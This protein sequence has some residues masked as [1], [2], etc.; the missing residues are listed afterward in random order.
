[1]RKS[2]IV[3]CSKVALLAAG[4][5]LVIGIGLYFGSSGYEVENRVGD[6]V[7]SAGVTPNNITAGDNITVWAN[8]KYV[9]S[10]NF[11]VIAYPP[12]EFTS[13]GPVGNLISHSYP[14]RLI[15]EVNVWPQRSWGETWQYFK[16]T[17]PGIYELVASATAPN[18]DNSIVSITV[19]L[20]VEVKPGLNPI[21][22]TTTTTIPTQTTTA[23]TTITY[24]T[25]TPPV[26]TR[27]A[28]SPHAPI[29]IVGDNS[30]TPANGVNGG[31]T[32][33]END[34]YVIEN[35]AINASG[36]NGI[37]IQNTTKYFV[38]RNCLVENGGSSYSGIGLDNV[39]NGRI[40]NNT[41]ENNLNFDIALFSSSSNTLTNNTC[42]NSPCGIYL[43]LIPIYGT[44]T[45]LSYNTVENN[46]SDGIH[47]DPSSDNNI[48]DNNT[49]RNNG[50]GIFLDFSSEYNILDNNTCN[51]NGDRGIYLQ[52]HS[53]NNT[54]T[55]N[56]CSSNSEG[57]SLLASYYNNLP[58]NICESNTRFGIWISSDN[59]NLINNT[60][61]NNGD[62]IHLDTSYHDNLI[63]NTCSNNSSYGICLEYS[64]INTLANNT[65]NNNSYGICLYPSSHDNL[66]GNTCSGNS[67]YGIYLSGSVLYT[68]MGTA[69]RYFSSCNNL[70]G[71]ACE[72]N[73]Y[74]IYLSSS[75]S[76]TISHNY[77][78][79]NTE[80]NAFDDNTNYWDNGSVGNYWSDWQPGDNIDG[81]ILTS[82][83]GVT[84]DQ[85][86]PIAGGTN[87]DY[88]P[89]VL[90]NVTT[91]TTAPAGPYISLQGVELETKSIYPNP[92]LCASVFVYASVPLYKLTLFVNGAYEGTSFEPYRNSTSYVEIY[93]AQ[94]S[95]QAMPIIAGRTYEIT[96]VATFQD[97]SISTASASVVAG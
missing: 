54:L 39:I 93:K 95:N 77:L 83:N 26:T 33:T 97:N 66:T 87:H 36:A 91:T 43:G 89:L 64:S 9:G 46:S 68:P 28:T 59:C 63:N 38:I 30:F 79:N 17:P 44:T 3:L 2:H 19:E 31:G 58:S 90:P 80:N 47:L 7:L 55:G 75:N 27:T 62:G 86:R 48:L 1:L 18:P 53:S 70:T 13:F 23:T 11:T 15:Q 5:A 10:D 60:C 81:T 25:T 61:R 34:P 37:Y 71:N 50:D 40:E 69:Y 88:Y 22:Q 78:L 24:T 52:Q 92:Y 41:C 45:T 67:N 56:T 84:V 20:S 76:N 57:I 73:G 72:N 85:P 51:N 65:C 6:W 32:G 21:T 96:F 8:I 49:C 94:P 16:P 12:S 74:G 29:S 4:V 82:S 35:W 42:R 14:V